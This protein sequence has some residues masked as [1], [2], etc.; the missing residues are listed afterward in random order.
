MLQAMLSFRLKYSQG[1]RSSIKSTQIKNKE[2]NQR[3]VKKKFYVSSTINSSNTINASP[4][5]IRI[6]TPRRY[7]FFN[8]LKLINQRHTGS[9]IRFLISFRHFRSISD[10]IT[11]FQSQFID[12]IGLH[13][14]DRLCSG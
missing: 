8:L 4:L 1:L 9:R 10:R 11:K 7:V 14:G 12:D 6:P 13:T 3:D 5:K 2:F